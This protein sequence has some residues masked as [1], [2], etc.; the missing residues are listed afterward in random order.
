MKN[1]KIFYLKIFI[2]FFFFLVVKFSVYL[3]RHVFEMFVLITKIKFN[4]VFTFSISN[5]FFDSKGNCLD[6]YFT[7]HG[8][9]FKGKLYIFRGS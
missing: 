2:F 5:V 3:N 4:A 9:R 1:I 7:A 8:L 6:F